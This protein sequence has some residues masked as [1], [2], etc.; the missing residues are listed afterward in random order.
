[1][2]ALP[3][4]LHGAVDLHVH[5]APDVVPRPFDDIE[6]AR[7]AARAGF[8]AIVLKNHV[9]PTM[10]RAYLVRQIVPGIAI[11]GGIVLNDSLGGFNLAAVAAAL[12][13]G[14]RVIWMPTK[15]AHNHKLH[16]GGHGGLTVFDA[17]GELRHHV[18]DIL[19]LIANSNAILATGHL[20]PAE[21]AAVIRYAYMQGLRCMVVTHPEWS[22][23]LY[24]LEL[25]RDLARY[26]VFFERCFASTANAPLAHAISAIGVDS[27]ILS[28]GLGQ[29][30]TPSPAQGPILFAE[31]LRAAGF[32]PGNLRSM[33][34][35]NP[36]HLLK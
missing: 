8:S 14:A 33:M 15:S 21:G 29:S 20:S 30:A 26:G 24:P 35:N 2:A 25:Q 31:Q 19:L 23:T 28:T 12:E 5:S 27:T 4:Y 3:D 11:H 32:S 10:D 16:E 22:A 36:A 7:E 1:M 6:L 17:H 13:L 18:K 34:V 9:V